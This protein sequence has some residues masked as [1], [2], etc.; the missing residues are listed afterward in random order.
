MFQIAYKVFDEQHRLT[1]QVLRIILLCYINPQR[2]HLLFIHEFI[3]QVVSAFPHT[4][5]SLIRIG[6]LTQFHP[7]RLTTSAYNMDQL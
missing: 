2:H 5:Q 3:I 4:S 7:N 1:F 6:M